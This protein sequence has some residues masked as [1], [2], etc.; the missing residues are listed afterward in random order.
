M[1][2]ASDNFPIN[3]YNYMNQKH[4]FKIIFFLTFTFEQLFA[5]GVWTQKANYPDSVSGAVGFSIGDK[6][7]LGLGW[8]PYQTNA[9]WEYNP[10]IN[11]WIQKGNF[12]GIFMG[13]SVGFTING[14]GY[15]GTGLSG[16]SNTFHN[17]FWQYDSPG[18]TWLQKASFGGV[19]R[20]EATGFSI[21]DKGYIGTGWNQSNGYK[22]DFWEYNSSTD[23][24]IQKADFPGTSRVGAS[25]F[26][27]NGRGYIGLGSDSSGFK[28][29]LWEYNP[30]SDQWTQKSDFPS[31]PRLRAVCFVINNVCYL[32]TGYSAS[33]R[34]NDF[35]KYNDVTDTW[36]QMASV[37][38]L[39]RQA[40]VG[41]AINNKGYIGT[42]ADVGSPY[43]Y[44]YWEYSP[45][46]I[47]G[48]QEV[49]KI[50]LN[51][52]PNP[53]SFQTILYTDKT[54]VNATITIKNTFGQIVKQIKNISG[55]TI[56]L[57]RDGL[58]EGS[59]PV[60]LTEGNKIIATTKLIIID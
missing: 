16:P 9:F 32:G 14:K 25:G 39:M 57:F 11:Q 31:N 58:P 52:F 27:L 10:S 6:G 54:L 4:Y 29:D 7:Y 34:L 20:S 48:V 45:D 26:S 17:E 60:T 59:Y 53:F 50:K 33:G 5:Q 36:T 21:N 47:T 19:P 24:W 28:K 18:D 51:I 13:H 42:G 37:G 22:K 40:S 56:N 35:W 3:L 1:Q 2:I 38:T 46:S 43:Y 30:I 8:N 15:I 49:E 23:Q 12:P 41:F 55:Q 44:D